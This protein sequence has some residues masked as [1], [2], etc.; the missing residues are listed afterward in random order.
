[1]FSSCFVSA[2]NARRSAPARGTGAPAAAGAAGAG[3]AAPV[4]APRRR[5]EHAGGAPR[6]GRSKDRARRDAAAA[7]ARSMLHRR[8]RRRSGSPAGTRGGRGCD[9]VHAACARSRRREPR[10]GA[11]AAQRAPPRAR[12]LHF[13]LPACALLSQQGLWVFAKCRLRKSSR[14]L[15]LRTRRRCR[16]RRAGGGAF[17]CGNFCRAWPCTRFDNAPPGPRAAGTSTPCC[18]RAT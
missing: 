3:P 7:L 9:V 16:R 6:R 5:G 14:R 8:R 2:W 17:S 12:A 15:C 10:G 18:R 13:C 1:M 11:A 4:A